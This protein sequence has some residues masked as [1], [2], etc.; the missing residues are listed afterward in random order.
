M[1]KS[2][3]KT[4]AHLSLLAANIIY[5][6]NYVIAKAVMPDQIKPLALVAV[7]SISAASLFWITSLFLPKEKVSRKDLLFLLFCSLF[8]VVTNQVLFLVGLN[9]TSPV[10]SSII[11]S[12]NPIFAFILAALILRENITFL[13]GI[14]LSIGLTGVLLLI[15]ENGT[16]DISSRTFLGDLATL[17]N[18]ISW[19]FYT[20]IIKR[21]LEKYHPVTVM[22]WTFF[23]GMF[24]TISIGYPQWSRTEWS[25]ITFNGW[26]GIGFVVL[27]ATYVG[28]LL[29]AFGLRR[30]SPTIVSTYT[31]LN[32]VIAAYL[33]TIMGQD[34]I[35][36]HMILAAVL[37]FT[38]VFVVSWQKKA[39]PA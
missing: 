10:N 38:G 9:Y 1:H 18:T 17:I 39:P 20:V 29:I 27:F 31:Y 8:G 14:G 16:P 23:F 34:R 30:L 15:L 19:A 25:A 33:A 4:W 3:V 24:I 2:R 36:L 32:P 11:V 12:T 21:M 7:R 37:I 5:G 6:V 26:L 28:Y 35:D 13:K 22:K